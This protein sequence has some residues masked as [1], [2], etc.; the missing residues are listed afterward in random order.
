MDA[1][2]QQ[3]EQRSGH[4]AESLGRQQA[5]EE[6]GLP[7][8]PTSEAYS[9]TGDA[10]TPHLNVDPLRQNV[11]YVY[12]SAQ[13]AQ[14]SKEDLGVVRTQP[15]PGMEGR[16]EAVVRVGPGVGMPGVG[17][18]P[19]GPEERVHISGRSQPEGYLEP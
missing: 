2:E 10:P 12:P 17:A 1:S 9:G 5:E 15:E 18:M 6:M 3:L 8:Q 13:D 14:G 7:A 19:K 11:A 16:G 4:M